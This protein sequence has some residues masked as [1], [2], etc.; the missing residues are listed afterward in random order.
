MEVELRVTVKVEPYADTLSDFTD[1]ALQEAAKEAIDQAMLFADGSG[2]KYALAGRV[3]IGY[4]ETEIINPCNETEIEG[5][6]APWLEEHLRKTVFG[7]EFKRKMYSTPGKPWWC[8][9]ADY[10]NHEPSCENYKAN[11]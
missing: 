10:P 6:V 5:Y 1:G 11:D 4:V 8:C 7:P 9:K 3:S 2:Y